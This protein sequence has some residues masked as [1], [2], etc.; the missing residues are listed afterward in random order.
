VTA[1]PADQF[2][3]FVWFETYEAETWNRQRAADPERFEVPSCLPVCVGDEFHTSGFAVV[4][5]SVA[6]LIA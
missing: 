6:R 3:A 1:I 4:E 5:N 2:E